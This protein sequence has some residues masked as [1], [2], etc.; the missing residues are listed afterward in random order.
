MS[1][2]TTFQFFFKESCT[3]FCR[4]YTNHSLCFNYSCWS[5]FWKCTVTDCLDDDGHPSS[6]CKWS[7]LMIVLSVDLAKLWSSSYYSVARWQILKNYT[8]QK[9]YECGFHIIYGF[10]YWCMLLTLAEQEWFCLST[11]IVRWQRMNDIFVVR[12]ICWCSL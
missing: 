5:Q 9:G 3:C 12:T 7:K 11:Y 6:S 10:I 4:P 8:F 2:S 1:T